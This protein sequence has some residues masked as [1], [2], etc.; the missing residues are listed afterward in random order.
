MLLLND[1]QSNERLSLTQRL[2]INLM[3]QSAAAELVVIQDEAIARYTA[4]SVSEMLGPEQCRASTNKAAYQRNLRD[5]LAHVTEWP[6]NFVLVVTQPLQSFPCLDALDA[7]APPWHSS[8]RATTA[9][10]IHRSAAR[11]SVGPSHMNRR[12]RPSSSA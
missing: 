11:H 12:L 1:P 4:E 2:M 6:E 8:S 9:T 7:T 10:A 5:V 3:V